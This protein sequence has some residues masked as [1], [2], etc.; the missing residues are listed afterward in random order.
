MCDASDF[1]IGAMLGQRVEK[2]SRVIYYASRTLD[3]SQVNYTVTK[4]EFLAVV[5]ALEKFRPYLLGSHVTIFT[6][7]S[8]IKYLMTKKDAKARLVHWMLLLQEFDIEIKDKKGCE[9]VVVDHL[10]RL[11]T[12]PSEFSINDSFPDEHILSLHPVPWFTDIVNY[13]VTNKF[14]SD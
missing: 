1:A 6:D 10:S 2:C 12:S 4:K 9:N 13:L 5:F 7:H 11:R 3:S 8:A 14:P